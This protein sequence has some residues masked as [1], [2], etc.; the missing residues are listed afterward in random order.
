MIAYIDMFSGIS[1]DMT[2]GALIDLGVP[3][4]WLE[5]QLSG[6]LKGFHLKTQIV[7]KHHLRATDIVVDEIEDTRVSRHYTDIKA[8][9]NNSSLPEKVKENSL[10]AFK[11]IAEA[12]SVIHGKDM[13]TIHFH[14][15]GGVDS[16]VDIVGSFLCVAYLDIETVYASKVPLGSGFVSCAHGEIPVPV[17]ATL[18][19]LKGVP[20]RPS[21]AKTEIV[22]P[23]GAAIVTTL[24]AGFGS[25][26]EMM[27]QQV[28][29]G[30]G[31]RDTG[32]VHP[33]LLRIVLGTGT[34]D[35]IDPATAIRKET[36]YV[37]K[38]NV[39]DMSPEVLGFLMEILFENK[40]LDV[41]YVPVQMKKN[42]PG[43]QIEVI[44]QKKDLDAVICI[45]LEQT[46]SI[47]VRYHECE[48]SFLSRQTA[49]AETVFGRLEVKKI[50]NPDHSI[51]FVPEYEVARKVA[52]EKKLPIKDVYNRILRDANPL[53]P[54]HLT[55][56]GP[57]YRTAR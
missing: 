53:D 22:T 43:T 8:L 54:I 34:N 38:T 2:L 31:K 21:D 5:E 50:I 18:A 52:R 17:P 45:I 7:F 47:G 57:D 42:R 3:V 23:T 12:E 37:V 40:A 46:S 19:I 33:N 44:C 55:G 4:G 15:I 24:A 14:E 9:I 25:M 41:S 6:I 10:S 27:V 11:K 30:S 26:P 32:S 16:I 29:Y 49:V 35:Q 20:I 36:I 56:E 1:G 28:G 39:D 48:R 51:R 13:D